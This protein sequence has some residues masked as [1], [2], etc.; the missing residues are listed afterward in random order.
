MFYHRSNSFRPLALATRARFGRCF[1][2]APDGGIPLASD[3]TA[4][5]RTSRRFG[6]VAL[7]TRH[8]C[9]RLVA[10]AEV[11]ALAISQED[12][13]GHDE[14]GALRCYFPEWGSAAGYL[15]AC[16]CCASPA[17]LEIRN[18][19]GAE[20]MQ[21]CG[22]PEHSP[23]AW[24]DFFAAHYPSSP[25]S[26]VESADTAS[27]GFGYLCLT[28]PLVC[29][30]FCLRSLAIVFEAFGDERLPIS[31]TLRT[32]EVV[33]RREIVPAHLTHNG[34]ILSVGE[35]S[36][37]LQIAIPTVQAIALTCRHGCYSLHLLGADDRLILT[38]AD[39]AGRLAEASWHG[40]LFATF[41][42]VS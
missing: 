4:I 25:A 37:R 15:R 12:G 31:C 30:P 13:S 2:T 21:L 14:S 24:S 39:G 33:H 28:R 6:P 1:R 19:Q 34:A 11:P 23:H 7:Q 9:A 38:L 29:F 42:G 20:F 5:L 35:D 27:A 32:A 36:V 8:A 41:P 22:L 40:A 18:R 17:R 10:I 16:T 26:F 3:W